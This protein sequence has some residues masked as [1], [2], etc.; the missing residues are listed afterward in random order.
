VL[1]KLKQTEAARKLRRDTGTPW[2]L[3]AG[4]RPPAAMP[5]RMTLT[6]KLLGRAAERLRRCKA[7]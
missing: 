1:K 4:V 6:D 2:E 3:A 5:F 7:F